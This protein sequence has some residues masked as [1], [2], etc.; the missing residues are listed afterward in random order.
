MKRLFVAIRVDARDKLLQAYQTIRHNLTGQ[1]IN[2]VNENN[3]HLT[4]KYLGNTPDE[5]VAEI[6][7]CLQKVV[8]HHTTFGFDI[9]GFG[10]FGNLRFPRVLWLG[11]HSGEELANTQQFIHEKLAEWG[12]KEDYSVYKPHLTIGRV[13]HFNKPDTLLAL[14]AEYANLL[15]QHEQVKEIILYESIL[16]PTGPVYNALGKYPL[17]PV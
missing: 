11:I 4:L 16:K 10:Y 7:H 17:A 8:A 9:K 5:K 6:D 13:K 3:L 12:E 15:L 14:E 2:W 1:P